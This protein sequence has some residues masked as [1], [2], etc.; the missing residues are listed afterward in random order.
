MRRLVLEQRLGFAATVGPDGR[1]NLSPKGTTS[2]LDEERLFFADIH[3][4][5]TVRNLE[6]NPAIEINVVDPVVRKGYRFKGKA[7]L[8]SEGR[9]YEQALAL[10]AE[11]GYDARR[12]RIRTVVLVEVERCAALISPAY[13]GG[14]SEDAVAARWESHFADLAAARR[15]G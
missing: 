1:P 8:H 13:D 7:T 9:I 11:R 4:P 5:Q 10:L 15:G 2:V 14:A 6:S 3:S 12:E